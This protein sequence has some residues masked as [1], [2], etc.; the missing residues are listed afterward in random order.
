MPSCPARTSINLHGQSQC[1][2][3]PT[4]PK[5]YITLSRASGSHDTVVEAQRMKA[6]AGGK[7]YAI[8]ISLGSSL[9][10]AMSIP[11]VLSNILASLPRVRWIVDSNT[12]R[13]HKFGTPSL[14]GFIPG[15]FSTEMLLRDQNQ[16]KP[17]LASCLYHLTY[18]L[19][20]FMDGTVRD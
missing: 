19:V 12:Y 5:A 16:S 1:Y 9:E 8:M 2:W 11:P 4:R 14:K 17:N 7:T 18:S 13:P 20:V 10:V 6:I 15:T 3:S